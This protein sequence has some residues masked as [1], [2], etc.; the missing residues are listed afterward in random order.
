VLQTVFNL[1]WRGTSYKEVVVRPV[2]DAVGSAL[3]NVP[4]ERMVQ[5]VVRR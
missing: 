2:G 1:P 4:Q 3:L 5:L